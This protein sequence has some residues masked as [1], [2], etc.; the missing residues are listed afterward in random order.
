MMRRVRPIALAA[1]V[2]GSTVSCSAFLDFDL[3]GSDAADAGAVDGAAPVL[4]PPPVPLPQPPANAGKGDARPL[5]ETQDFGRPA[6]GSTPAAKTQVIANVGLKAFDFT[7]S[8][9]NGGASVFTIAPTTGTVAPG[10]QATITIT[11]RKVPDTGG[12]A[13]NLYGDTLS[14]TTTVP[15]EAPLA[16]PLNLTPVG[17]VLSF[18]PTVIDFDTVRNDQ[19]RPL[20]VV[21]SGNAAVTISYT[22]NGAAFEV[23]GASVTVPSRASRP[24]TVTCA[25]KGDGAKSGSVTF[26]N[27]SVPLCK[28]LPAPVTLLCRSI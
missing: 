1:M 21:N 4:E 25:P 28:L 11:P 23:T 20:W 26:T 14:V 24:V 2:M 22:K 12:A 5:P 13:E 19:E 17:A 27:P 15:G 6:C 9:I 10:G 3:S 18:D 8:L 7:A 16:I